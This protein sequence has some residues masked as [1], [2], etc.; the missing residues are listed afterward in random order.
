MPP[1]PHRAGR[2]HGAEGAR[3]DA[4]LIRRLRRA[5]VL[6]AV[7][8][9]AGLLAELTMLRHWKGPIQLVPWVVVVALLA[10]SALLWRDAATRTAVRV[11]RVL[12]GVSA[13][14]SAVGVWQHIEGNMETAALSVAWATKWDAL[15]PGERLWQA[16]TGGAGI[17]PP[18]VPGFLAL[19]G[20][21]LVCATIGADADAPSSVSD[22]SGGSSPRH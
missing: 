15:S 12:A 3:G 9:L 13:L 19:V 16:A 4:A 5:I 2:P 6:I 8:T 21:M 22:S 1:A 18:L 11:A 20:I 14:A 10:A 7:L 17:A